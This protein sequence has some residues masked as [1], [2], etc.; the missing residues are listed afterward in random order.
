MAKLA[1]F[2]KAHVK[3]ASRESQQEACHWDDPHAW[4]EHSAG[5]NWWAWPQWGW[6][7]WSGMW[8][9]PG[10]HHSMPPQA[11]SSARAPQPLP[12]LVR[13]KPVA[14]P[15]LVEDKPDAAPSLV[16]EKPVATPSLVEEKPVA[17]PALVE[18]KPDA[19][20]EEPGSLINRLLQTDTGMEEDTKAKAPPGASVMKSVFQIQHLVFRPRHN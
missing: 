12:S 9:W 4:R 15:S 16:E 5:D 11:S 8:G 14:A 2:G 19:E 20:E 13:D 6:D 1:T 7:D 17:A 3:P 10:A 18:D